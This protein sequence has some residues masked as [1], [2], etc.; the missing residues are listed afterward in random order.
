MALNMWTE[1]QDDYKR[2]ERL[3]EYVGKE[4]LAKWKLNS[5]H[6]KEKLKRVSFLHVFVIVRGYYFL[7]NKF[8]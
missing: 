6:C 8:I 5:H 7:S 1:I 2:C 3:H 4:V